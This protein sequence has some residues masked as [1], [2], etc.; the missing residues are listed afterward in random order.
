[1]MFLQSWPLGSWGVTI[2]AYI[3]ANTGGLGSGAFSS[4]FIGYSTLAAAVGSL[5]S[6]YLVGVVGDRL[7]P[8]RWLLAG[9]NLAS[10]AA[11]MGLLASE[12]E[13]AFFVWLCVY[14][15]CYF[16]VVTLCN[17]IGLANLNRPEQEFPLLRLYGAIGWIAAGVFV[18]F[19]WPWMFGSSIESLRTPFAIGAVANLAMAIYALT[20]P[21][22]GPAVRLDTGPPLPRRQ[23][24]KLL[25]DPKLR[26]FL[27]ASFFAC[28]PSMAYNNFCNPFLNHTKFPAPAAVMTLGQL[29]EIAVLATMPMVLRR[30]SLGSL[31]VWGMAAW[32]ARYGLLTAAAGTGV[33]WPV[34]LAILLHGPCFAFIYVVGPMLADRFTNHQDRGAAQGLYAVAS[35]GL[36]HVVGAL[37]VGAMQAAVLTPDGVNPPPYDWTTF[38]AIA[39][40]VSVVSLVVLFRCVNPSRH[41]PTTD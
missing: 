29:S 2:G 9:L 34:Y 17:T 20:L 5:V 30:L 8:P 28:V 39:S 37:A 40:A 38:W 41:S 24:G 3:A 16:P 7:V 13:F 22:T 35:S 25:A 11:A 33:A 10:A 4:G 19:A 27:V 31:Y 18:G 26:W 12:S 6:P 32:V 21:R 23:A 1:M 36:G 14:F 15:Q